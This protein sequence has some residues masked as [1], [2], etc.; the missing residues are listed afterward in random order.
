VATQFKEVDPNQG[1]DDNVAPIPEMMVPLKGTNDILLTDAAGIGLPLSEKPNMLEISEVK[2]FVRRSLP[3]PHKFRLKGKALPGKNGLLVQA[4]R[5][6]IVTATLRVYVLEPRKVRLAVRPL[7]T[8]QGV[9]HAKNLP[10]TAAFVKKMNDI[11]GPQA[12]VLIELVPS[13]PALI[14]DA[15]QN[16]RQIGAFKVDP[17]TGLKIPDEEKG[18]FPAKIPLYTRIPGKYNNFAPVFSFLPVFKSYLENNPV[19][20]TDFTIF[21]VHAIDTASGHTFGATD[22]ESHKFALVSEDADARQWAHEVGHHLGAEDSEK[23][24][25]LLME[26]GE[27]GEKISVQDAVNVFNRLHT[28]T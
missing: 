1:V 3:N 24:K 25:K 11:W 16:A 28:H 9:F 17:V 14:W 18:K 5:G 7:Q 12:N 15:E 4:V 10:D 2:G 13:T 20:N 22:T 26:S 19:K 23:G 21:V 6:T 27:E 8:A